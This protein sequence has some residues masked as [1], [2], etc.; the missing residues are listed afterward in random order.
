M[1]SSRSSHINQLL[2]P[3]KGIISVLEQIKQ[4]PKFKKLLNF[5]LNALISFITP[6][7]PKFRENAMFVIK[8]QLHINIIQALENHSS[9]D[10]IVLV[11]S[12][13]FFLKLNQF[14][15]F[16]QTNKKN[17]CHVLEKLIGYGNNRNEEIVQ[18]LVEG[19]IMKG[20]NSTLNNPDY[21][22]SKESIKQLLSLINVFIVNPAIALKFIEQNTLE[23]IMNCLRSKNIEDVSQIQGLETLNNFLNY[24]SVLQKV[25]Q[26]QIIPQFCETLY[27]CVLS[28]LS[29]SL[30]F[31]FIQKI[32]QTKEGLEYV[33]QCN[34]IKTIVSIMSCLSGDK[35]ISNLGSYILSR[36]IN[37][38][39]I[40]NALRDLKQQSGDLIF[41]SALLSNLV[42]ASEQME[43]LIEKGD[44][45]KEVLNLVK[46]FKDN[47]QEDNVC[48]L[49]N[50]FITLARIAN[51]NSKQAK[52]L[53]NEGGIDI[54]SDFVENDN[55]QVFISIIETF[56]LLL[57]SYD[58]AFDI[59]K[60][61]G[62]IKTIIDFADTVHSDNVLV[63][64]SISQFLSII[65]N[66]KEGASYII[67]NNAIFL[68]IKIF[69]ACKKYKN[70]IENVTKILSQL[71][72]DKASVKQL[73]QKTFIQEIIEVCSDHPEWRKSCQYSI[74]CIS[75]LVNHNKQL[76]DTLKD[77]DIVE[78]LISIV[79]KKAYMLILSKESQQDDESYEEIEGNVEYDQSDLE[80]I[81]K[82]KKENKVVEE[83]NEKLEQKI[84]KTS[85]DILQFVFTIDDIMSISEQIEGLYDELVSQNEPDRQQEY[86]ILLEMS[87]IKLGLGISILPTESLEMGVHQICLKISKTFIN[88]L[89]Q[90]PNNQFENEEIIIA[91]NLFYLYTSELFENDQTQSQY[92]SLRFIDYF[93]ELSSNI[94][95]KFTKNPLRQHLKCLLLIL[96]RQNP[97]KPQ[98]KIIRTQNSNNK[99]GKQ[100]TLP[101]VTLIKNIVD[102]IKKN[103]EDFDL[104]ILSLD[105]LILLT[106][107]GKQFQQEDLLINLLVE[108]GA[109]KF[110][111]SNLE[112]FINAELGVRCFSFLEIA[113]KQQEQLVTESLIKLKALPVLMNYIVSMNNS[114]LI[115]QAAQEILQILSN[116]QEN[117]FQKNEDSTSISAL[118]QKSNNVFQTNQSPQKQN[119]IYNISQI[120]QNTIIQNETGLQEE[121]F[122]QLI[123]SIDPEQNSS[124]KNFSLQNSS[125]SLESITNYV[126]IDRNLE[127]MIGFDIIIAINNLIGYIII[128]DENELALTGNLFVSERLLVGSLQIIIRILQS[129][130]NQK[131]KALNQITDSLLIQKILSLLNLKQHSVL[132]VLNTAI[133]FEELLKEEILREETLNLVNEQKICELLFTLLEKMNSLE[134][135]EVSQQ[136]YRLI[137][138][139]AQI[140]PQSASQLSNKDFVK[141]ILRKIKVL[142]TSDTAKIQSQLSE[143]LK[144]FLTLAESQKT[145]EIILNE[146]GLE[147]LYMIIK[148]QNIRISEEKIEELIQD[149]CN[150]I[151][152]LSSSKNF[153]QYLTNEFFAIIIQ[154]LEKNANA[155]KQVCY[156]YL[157]VLNK[158][159]GASKKFIQQLAS[160]N[161]DDVIQNVQ[162]EHSS[163]R[164]I[165]QLCNDL[166]QNFKTDNTIISNKQ[167]VSSLKI[168]DPE[169]VKKISKLSNSYNG[170]IPQDKAQVLK[171]NK[172]LIQQIIVFLKSKDLEVLKATL[173]LITSLS[174]ESTE[175]K[176]EILESDIPNI[177]LNEILIQNKSDNSMILLCF[178]AVNANL[179]LFNQM[180]QFS[181]K[182]LD[183]ETTTELFNMQ[184]YKEIA[185]L[186]KIFSSLQ[187]YT[188]CLELI[189]NQSVQASE[190]VLEFLSLSVQCSPTNILI[191]NEKF[192]SILENLAQRVQESDFFNLYSSI[193]QV[194]SSIVRNEE[195]FDYIMNSELLKTVFKN[196]NSQSLQALEKNEKILQK[197]S[198]LTFLYYLLELTS[199]LTDNEFDKTVLIQLNA[200]ENLINLIKKLLNSQQEFVDPYSLKILKQLF[201]CIKTIQK[202]RSTARVV[203]SLNA[204]KILISFCQ[205]INNQ[206]K[207]F[208]NLLSLTKIPEKPSIKTIEGSL[209]IQDQ[210][211]ESISLSIHAVTGNKSQIESLEPFKSKSNFNKLLKQILNERYESVLV[212]AKIVNTIESCLRY[213]NKEIISQFIDEVKQFEP[214]ISSIKKMYPNIQCI[215]TSCNN[216]LQIIG[217]SDPRD[218][219]YVQENNRRLTID[220]KRLSSS[221][222]KQDESSL[223]DSQILANLQQFQ[224]SKN[225]TVSEISQL[226]KQFENIPAKQTLKEES[227]LLTT[228]L[229]CVQSF[230]KDIEKAQ[231]LQSIGLAETLVEYIKKREECKLEIILQIL[232][233]MYCYPKVVQKSKVVAAFI[234]IIQKFLN[235]LVKNTEIKNFSKQAEGLKYSAIILS[236]AGPFPA[237]LQLIYQANIVE[238][239][240]S[241][242]RQTYKGEYIES[243]TQCLETLAKICSSKQISQQFLEKG[244]NLVLENIFQTKEN[245]HSL[246]ISACYVLGKVSQNSAIQSKFFYLAP[247]LIEKINQCKENSLVFSKACFAIASMVFNNDKHQSEILNKNP[248]FLNLLIEVSNKF[249]QNDND[250]ISNVCMLLNSIC[251]KNNEA[252]QIVG[253]TNTIQLLVNISKSDTLSDST[254]Q[255]SLKTIGNLSLLEQNSI[256]IVKT[257]FME[258]VSQIFKSKRETNK[259]LSTFSLEIL[260]NICAVIKKVEEREDYY[261]ILVKEG[262]LKLMIDCMVM[263]EEVSK[264]IIEIICCVIQSDSINQEFCKL[265]GVKIT[266]QILEE[267]K[268]EMNILINLL[269]ILQYLTTLTQN[270][271]L[272]QISKTKLMSILFNNIMKVKDS[273][274]ISKAFKIIFNMAQNQNNL[275]LLNQDKSLA[276]FIN[277][278]DPISIDDSAL[279]DYITLLNSLLSSEQIQSMI[280]KKQLSQIIVSLQNKLENIE[281]VDSSLN[282][283]EKLALN[284]QSIDS[285]ISSNTLSY[286]NEVLK[287]LLAKQQ[288]SQKVLR[289]LEI[290]SSSSD[291]SKSVVADSSL[292]LLERLLKETQ[293]APEIYKMIQNTQKNIEKGVSNVTRQS[294]IT[295]ELKEFVYKGSIAK[296]Y[297]ENGTSSKL[298]IYVTNDLKEINCKK[299]GK[300]TVKSKWKMPI[301][302]IQQIKSNYE[303]DP[304]GFS[305]SHFALSFRKKPEPETCFS[306]VGPPSSVRKCFFVHCGS[307]FEKDKW[308]QYLNDLIQ[309]SQEQFKNIKIKF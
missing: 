56:Q 181:H 6:P 229:S 300:Q 285:L 169:I 11:M 2:K 121:D 188:F 89:D 267:G 196:A 304:Q 116:Y 207:S 133:A 165:K 147:C 228:L 99:S 66:Q 26:K 14:D 235:N 82:M 180:N 49:K 123:A 90:L 111:I 245:N 97:N 190:R 32:I 64:R 200:V 77:L 283:I 46:Q 102:L 170:F 76:V 255:Q 266:V 137:F 231:Q 136:L 122:K 5:Q 226:L 163:D 27:D 294:L 289:I 274:Y 264:I 189:E 272:E 13:F 262:F 37:E 18:L 59:I 144:C 95:S 96:K 240:L 293:K 201:E 55:P 17:S 33:K 108:E 179:Q 9:D 63:G 244:G 41:Q 128:Q 216:I 88:D 247:L 42:L 164:Q 222:A 44:V 278:F 127:Q 176:T 242:I 277:S 173:T 81:L 204:E 156:S 134:E 105:I 182:I 158:M 52:N 80:E 241:I 221:T 290:I 214:Y 154:A 291:Q 110:I 206:I 74:Q 258:C 305:K 259:E 225:I 186:K 307:K 45:L 120:Q 57:N 78:T 22:K 34:I 250:L 73:G 114:P 260:Q 48:V 91:M 112:L 192:L 131:E 209:L 237:A 7:N 145:Q 178:E 297:K 279:K 93:I 191:Q 184:S 254:I 198:F 23:S 276:L 103:I 275:Q 306:I 10:S 309:E 183:P 292:S 143:N 69:K 232:N 253:A 193:C 211:I 85:K 217:G 28:T 98:S 166:L 139:L 162:I 271:I 70:V 140:S 224:D 20:I 94:L 215:Q 261:K 171:P 153:E 47:V 303:A 21:I 273:K 252:K 83:N 233:Y 203:S 160:L 125:T 126:L 269:R 194:L 24:P 104:L 197:S 31:K 248:Q 84:L 113:L 30:G 268:V 256:K 60:K 58:G 152:K 239:L 288:I 213:Y 135:N 86:S 51:L 187:L 161:A 251:F 79:N 118:K 167:I 15:F 43:E 72:E 62:I 185:S 29:V 220:Q 3:D 282:L 157:M 168:N 25:I 257:Q 234:N 100:Q 119:E 174:Q 299:E 236:Y 205:K 50:C 146:N 132:I 175:T 150:V 195:S 124:N 8:E 142:M 202:D 287:K 151:V 19:N 101:A 36:I 67:Q 280:C 92:T 39:T 155:S 270:S 298:R 230:C 223:Q 115:R 263:P 141:S 265:E 308:V 218:L 117:D 71:A 148:N 210:V 208:K 61:K 249:I 246:L 107:L 219:K 130:I 75:Q 284:K 177:I 281:I 172:Q 227:A 106:Q 1:Y 109:F 296:L 68:L 87:I 243:A 38:N 302:M 286:L 12:S 159:L 301:N 295:D 35:S 129:S 65:A 53:V 149:T 138:T 199:R 212:S 4:N 16:N 40:Q 238:N 54:L